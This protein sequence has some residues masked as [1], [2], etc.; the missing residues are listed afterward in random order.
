MRRNP[1]NIQDHK[2][3]QSVSDGSLCNYL[4]YKKIEKLYIFEGANKIVLSSLVIN[5]RS[6]KYIYFLTSLSAE[7]NSYV[8]RYHRRI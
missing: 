1:Y 2:D 5:R 8:S 6:S 3:C 7:I 4:T